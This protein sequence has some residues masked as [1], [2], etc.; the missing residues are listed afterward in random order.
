MSFRRRVCLSQLEQDV[1]M[2]GV[3]YFLACLDGEERFLED[4]FNQDDP[5]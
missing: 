4:E 3:L 5:E 2:M 1:R